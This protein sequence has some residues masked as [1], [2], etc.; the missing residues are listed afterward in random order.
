ME[1]WE[2]FISGISGNEMNGMNYIEILVSLVMLAFLLLLEVRAG[3]PRQG[4]RIAATI[5]AMGSLLGMVLP[6][7]WSLQ[8][9]VQGEAV[10]L[11]EGYS[12]D[13]VRR[14]L[15]G[16]KGIDGIWEEEPVS[17]L[18]VFGYGLTREKWVGLKSPELVFHPGPPAEG[19]VWAEWPRRLNAGERLMVQGHW[20][21]RPGPVKLLLM[22][23]GAVLDSASAEGD[24]S[25]ET[26]PVQV[27]R[28]VYRLAAVRGKDTIE[29]EEI[30]V[31]TRLGQP[32]KILILAASPDFENKFL[33]NWLA[34]KGQQAAVRTAVSRDR[35][36]NSFVNM[37]PRSL[38]RLTEALLDGFD[39]VIADES[40]VAGDAGWSLLR[41]QV[42]EKGLGLIVKTDSSIIRWKPGM[43][44]LAVDSLV[45][46]VVGGALLGT[47]KLVYTALNTTYVRLMAARDAEYASYWSDILRLVGRRVESGDKWSWEP[48]PAVV[49]KNLNLSLQT[50]VTIPQGMV[51]KAGRSVSVY[52]A[53]DEMLPFC[54]KGRYWPETSG[55]IGIDDPGKDTSW[56]YIAARGSWTAMDREERRRETVVYIRE[57]SR[58][59]RL[60]KGAEG[61]PMPARAVVRVPVPKYWMYAGFLISVIFLWVEKKIF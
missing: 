21:G 60:P 46:P 41:R 44:T 61:T 35:Y 32:L 25:L 23:F 56:C 45:R 9:G 54:W 4:W 57:K 29:Q 39:V 20:Q 52:L 8:V 34:S 7:A 2:T 27:G 33:V 22:G 53:E 28:A 10:Y 15:A 11:T 50:S 58:E 30:P 37:K 14:F 5:V 16:H 48:E 1:D 31:E 24:F 43:R 47:G 55:W 51:W 59:V 17:R 40:V 19:V 36:Q 6:L 42:K 26:V 38:D 3:R 12:V 13:S 49:G 18:H